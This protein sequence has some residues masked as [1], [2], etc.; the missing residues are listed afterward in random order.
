[1]KEKIRILITGSSGFIGRFVTPRLSQLF[2]VVTVSL[3]ST[4]IDRIDLSQYNVILYLAGVAHQ[5]KKIPSDQYFDVNT[6]MP[7]E[8][9]LKAKEQGVT[10]F[11]YLSSIK[12]YGDNNGSYFDLNSIP[13]PTDAYGS[14]KLEAEILLRSISDDLINICI[15]RPPLVYGPSVKGNLR[16]LIRFKNKFGFLPLN[17]IHNKRS[18]VYVGNLLALI[19]IIIDN[20][21]SGTYIAGDARPYSTTEL[22]LSLTSVED[23]RLITIPKWIRLIIKLVKPNIYNRI[24]GDFVIDNLDSNKLLDFVPPYNLKEGIKETVNFEQNEI[25]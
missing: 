4:P 6:N 25:K 3:R 13:S 16:H 22:A 23:E 12:V 14:S 9:A 20:K 7:Y 2:N 19:I 5:S 8:M 24:F 1:M 18:M 10:Q 11:I 15:I 21:R 17:N